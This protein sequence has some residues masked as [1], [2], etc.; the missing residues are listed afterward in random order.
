M[1]RHSINL[2]GGIFFIF[3]WFEAIT[4]KGKIAPAVFGM[5][6]NLMNIVSSI[7]RIPKAGGVAYFADENK[8][9]I[10]DEYHF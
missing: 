6:S 4:K 2:L 5:G 10:R 9:H 1:I 8:V 3:E 7:K